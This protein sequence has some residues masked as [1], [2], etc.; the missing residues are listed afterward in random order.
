MTKT[1]KRKLVH[2]AV[3]AS[4]I[5]AISCGVVWLLLAAIGVFG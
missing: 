4:A 5:L 1:A 2:I 3:V